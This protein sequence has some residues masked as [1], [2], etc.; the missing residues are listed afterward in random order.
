MFGSVIK[1]NVQNFLSVQLL[2][3][4]DMET[5]TPHKR[6]RHSHCINHPCKS[7]VSVDGIDIQEI[8]FNVPISKAQGRLIFLLQCFEVH[9]R[10]IKFLVTFNFEFTEIV[11][12]LIWTSIIFEST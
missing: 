5:L 1:A 4:C 6:R 11:Y 10:T 2:L 7:N 3:L 12:E 8:I 9:K